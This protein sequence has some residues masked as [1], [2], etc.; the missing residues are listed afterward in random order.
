MKIKLKRNPLENGTKEGDSPV[1]VRFYR[2][3]VS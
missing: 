3:A 1:R 2:I